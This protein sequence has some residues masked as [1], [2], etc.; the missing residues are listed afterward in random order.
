MRFL[1]EPALSLSKGRAA[2][3][4]VLFDLLVDA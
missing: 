2:T 3:Q 1:Q 4:R